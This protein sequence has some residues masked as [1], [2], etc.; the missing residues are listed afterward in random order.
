[1]EKCIHDIQEVVEIIDS[2]FNNLKSYMKST[3]PVRY[4]RMERLDTEN[5]KLLEVLHRSVHTMPEAFETAHAITLLARN[6][7]KMYN[8]LEFPVHAVDDV[9]TSTLATKLTKAHEGMAVVYRLFVVD[10]ASQ[11]EKII[12]QLYDRLPDH[13]DHVAASGLFR[14]HTGSIELYVLYMTSILDHAY[15]NRDTVLQ[16][17]ISDTIELDKSFVLEE[18][19]WVNPFLSF[20]LVPV[21]TQCTSIAQVC[22]M[23]STSEFTVRAVT[24]AELAAACSE[25]ACGLVV[26]TRAQINNNLISAITPMNLAQGMTE[27]Q[28]AAR[29]FTPVQNTRAVDWQLDVLHAASA[30]FIVLETL[31]A[32]YRVLAP[33]TRAQYVVPREQLASVFARHNDRPH[34]INRLMWTKIKRHWN[35][36]VYEFMRAS[37]STVDVSIRAESLQRAAVSA[38]REDKSRHHVSAKIVSLAVQRAVKHTLTGLFDTS[39]H[40]TQ[41]YYINDLYDQFVALCSERVDAVRFTNREQELVAIERVYH[42]SIEQLFKNNRPTFGALAQNE[43]ILRTISNIILEVVDLHPQRDPARSSGIAG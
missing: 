32:V 33:W 37:A 20:N 36:H 16:K 39:V 19:E 3:Q 7:N 38:Y 22:E 34:N 30:R 28:A 40:D 35:R 10:I 23:I 2:Y 18:R 25:H 29:V 11:S 31:G 27:S 15:H 12:A 21:G 17:T 8:T 1:M 24:I 14:V 4:A 43:Y 5:A 6:I 41:N 42:A 26:I 9:I 13:T